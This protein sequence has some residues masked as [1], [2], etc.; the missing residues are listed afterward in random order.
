[1]DLGDRY[2]NEL[3]EEMQ[4]NG[5]FLA[6][7]VESHMD[8]HRFVTGMDGL[9]ILLVLPKLHGWRVP[10]SRNHGSLSHQFQV[11]QIVEAYDEVRRPREIAVVSLDWGTWKPIWVRDGFE[12]N[13]ARRGWD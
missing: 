1:M 12:S 8:Y 13:A 3:F 4:E 11:G 7:I 5:E 6:E 10:E 9:C 2:E